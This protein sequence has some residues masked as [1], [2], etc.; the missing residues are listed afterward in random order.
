MLVREIMQRDVLKMKPSESIQEAAKKMRE[1]HAAVAVVVE[2][3]EVKGIVT[4]WDL[5]IPNS[6]PSLSALATNDGN[7]CSYFNRVQAELLLR[8]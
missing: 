5:S 4:E 8:G 6:A 1:N 3:D 2:E 7:R